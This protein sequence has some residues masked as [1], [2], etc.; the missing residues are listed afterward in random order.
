MVLFHGFFSFVLR[1]QCLVHE[2]NADF[3]R[4]CYSYFSSLHTGLNY[5]IKLK[6]VIIIDFKR[7]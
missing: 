1:H 7:R 3:R 4:L 6:G 5:R 2:V